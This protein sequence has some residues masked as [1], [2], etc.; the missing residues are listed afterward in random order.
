VFKW[1]VGLAGAAAAAFFL[2]QVAFSG[3]GY[4]T[5]IGATSGVH[6]SF[7]DILS[8]HPRE[9]LTV[10]ACVEEECRTIQTGERDRQASVV[11]G[12]KSLTGSQPVEVRLRITDQAGKPV[13]RG[14]AVVEPEKL[15]P[16]GPDCA[17]T[18]WTAS[19]AVTG[20]ELTSQP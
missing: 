1:L 11:S 10:E 17:P 15:Q 16:N 20:N 12:E 19:V 6:V 9:A 2:V 3:S 4:C 8:E 13:F 7:T 18:A 14:S 5:D